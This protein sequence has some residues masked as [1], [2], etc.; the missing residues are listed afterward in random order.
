MPAS[1]LRHDI[2]RHG[3]TKVAT[4][5]GAVRGREARRVSLDPH[6]HGAD[7]ARSRDAASHEAVAAAAWQPR[8]TADTQTWRC[9]KRMVQAAL[10]MEGGTTYYGVGSGVDLFSA[11]EGRHADA[12]A[13]N[14]PAM[15]AHWCAA[16]HRDASQKPPG[17]SPT[18]RA[19]RWRSGTSIKWCFKKNG[20][21]SR[22][23]GS[24]RSRVR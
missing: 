18:M 24:A 11:M 22:I 21:S 10:P 1:K 13:E 14:A 2:G 7:M 3:A 16:R 19:Q 8:D 12:Q 20:A 4:G 15:C 5:R 17:A 6:E 23:Q 9:K